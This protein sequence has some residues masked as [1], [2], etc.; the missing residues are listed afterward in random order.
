MLRLRMLRNVRGGQE[1]VM[2]CNWMPK[3]RIILVKNY[4][5]LAIQRAKAVVIFKTIQE[6]IVWRTRTNSKFTWP[7][8]KIMRMKMFFSGLLL[9]LLHIFA[10]KNNRKHS[11]NDTFN[12]RISV[13]AL[14]L[15][16]F[17]NLNKRKWKKIQILSDSSSKNLV[18][19]KN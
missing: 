10:L 6:A 12:T 18:F 4:H 1:V 2:N 8:I 14:N 7:T 13:H 19:L 3:I 16:N 9:C 11:K 17:W 15:M 5:F